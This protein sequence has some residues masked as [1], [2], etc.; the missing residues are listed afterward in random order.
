MG[1]EYLF[2]VYDAATLK[3]VSKYVFKL[4]MNTKGFNSAFPQLKYGLMEPQLTLCI[5]NF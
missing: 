2:F 5:L 1:I 3:S 4:Q